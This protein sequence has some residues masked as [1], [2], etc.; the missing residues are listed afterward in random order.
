MTNN[1]QVHYGPALFTGASD[2][3][4]FI[5]VY[6]EAFAGHPYYEEYTVDQARAVWDEH[7]QHGRIILAKHGGKVIGLGCSVALSK[8]PQDVQDFLADMKVKGYLPDDFTPDAAWY[9]SELAVSEEY[10]NQGIAYELVR[11]RLIDVSHGRSAYYVM[12]T[13]SM[14][15]NSMHLYL[16]VGAETI[17][18]LQDVSDGDQ[19]KENGS[20][21]TVR[22]YLFGKSVEALHFLTGRLDRQEEGDSDEPE[23]TSSSDGDNSQEDAA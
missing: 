4:G 12:R 22:I 23:Q 21:S 9:M 5:K 8:A 6:R 2:I 19:V 17:P 18:E 13:D 7:F 11:H 14:E 15:S 10:R 3:D 20:K 1:E 16:R